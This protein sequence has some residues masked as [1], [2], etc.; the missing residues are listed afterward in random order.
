M[1]ISLLLKKYIKNC[2]GVIIYISDST[3]KSSLEDTV[4]WKKAINESE[5]LESCHVLN[6]K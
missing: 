4:K 2:V 6:R 3:D 1:N 5:N